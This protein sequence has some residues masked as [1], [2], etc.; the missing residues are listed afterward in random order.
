MHQYDLDDFVAFPR[1]EEASPDTLH[2]AQISLYLVEILHTVVCD[3]NYLLLLLK[4]VF[5]P[6]LFYILAS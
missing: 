3:C 5:P 2:L 6:L 1:I 4:V